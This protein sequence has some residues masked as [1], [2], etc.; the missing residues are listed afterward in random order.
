MSEI[1]DRIYIDKNDRELFNKLDQEDMLKFKG[2]RR[3]RKEQFFFAMALGFKN[4]ITYP[5][6]IKEGWF[7]TKDLQPEDDALLNAIAIYKTGSVEIL[8]NKAEVYKIAEE[9][10]HA[11]IRIL[12]DKIKSTPF[13]SF[14]KILEKE[15]HEIHKNMSF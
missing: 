12:C 8:S 6:E 14:G 2:G 3:T 4:D 15:L 1:P 9:Y 13:G 5:L 10:A 7:L 11:G